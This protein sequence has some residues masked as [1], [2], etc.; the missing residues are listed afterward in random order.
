MAF[1]P[2]SRVVVKGKID[3]FGVGTVRFCGPVKFSPEVWV[4]VELDQPRGR[5]D[6]FVNGERYFTCAPNHGILLKAAGVELF[7]GAPSVTSSTPSRPVA[8]PAPAPSPTSTQPSSAIV[9][10]PV[11]SDPIPVSVA[12]PASVQTRPQTLQSGN[13]SQPQSQLAAS[14]SASGASAPSTPARQS[15]APLPRTPAISGTPVRG[16]PARSRRDDESSSSEDTPSKSKEAA[17]TV[18]LAN[19]VSIQTKKLRELLAS[20]QGRPQE[21]KNYLD[22][23]VK[24]NESV[25]KDLKRLRLRNVELER[26]S[27]QLEIDVMTATKQLHDALAGE[28]SSEEQANQIR[29]QAGSIAQQLQQTKSEQAKTL[30]EAQK[31][32][33]SLRSELASVTS[34]LSDTKSEFADYRVQSEAEVSR[35][36]D[37]VNSLSA[38]VQQFQ[39]AAQNSQHNSAQVISDLELKLADAHSRFETLSQQAEARISAAALQYQRELNSLKDAVLSK[40]AEISSALSERSSLLS[41]LQATDQRV[42]ELVGKWDLDVVMGDPENARDAASLPSLQSE[43]RSSPH[44]LPLPVVVNPADLTLESPS[45]P[46]L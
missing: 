15:P 18:Q 9:P 46:E 3:Q 30:S 20:A 12:S 23:M 41:R 45:E 24:T 5:N 10:T 21:Y 37:Q 1:T 31:Q 40:R 28:L 42:A 26:R 39:Q 6:G 13:P 7:S 2:G 19:M 36:Q 25:E 29:N 38:Q 32:V 11:T 4:G 14:T 16:S 43:E 27:A 22:D 35:L 17:A 33:D 34:Q 8:S 44:Q